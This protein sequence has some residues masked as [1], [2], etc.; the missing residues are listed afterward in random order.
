MMRGEGITV[1]GSFDALRRL[2]VQASAPAAR[3]PSLGLISL[4]QPPPRMRP[5]RRAGFDSPA[6]AQS[7]ETTDTEAI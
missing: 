3:L 4:R 2:P 5:P 7:A 6:R 1:F